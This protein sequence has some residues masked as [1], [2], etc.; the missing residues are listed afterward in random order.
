LNKKK[1]KK[2]TKKK[3]RKKNEK[4]QL[5]KDRQKLKKLCSSI[6]K[7]LAAQDIDLLCGNLETAHLRSLVEMV[8]PLGENQEGNQGLKETA[9]QA[10]QLQLKRLYD[11]QL[12][13]KEKMAEKVALDKMME[14]KEVEERKSNKQDWT[15]DELSM[16]AK[17]IAKFPG[18]ATKRWEHITA[19]VN[20]VGKRNVKEVIQ[21]SKE[22]LAHKSIQATDAYATYLAKM[23]QKKATTELQ[24]K[25]TC[26]PLATTAEST[27][28]KLLQSVITSTATPSNVS[29]EKV[30][31]TAQDQ[32]LFEQ[33]LRTVPKDD[34]DRWQ[35]IAVIVQNKTKK[36]CMDRFKEIRQQILKRNQPTVNIQQST[37]NPK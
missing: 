35:K 36:Q 30:D 34:P 17:A 23:G 1:E 25:N 37:S 7:N 18:G 16:L 27:T 8:S 32:F 14:R 24:P 19:M 6:F 5:K 20:T 29:P 2:M 13:E 33:A 15:M 28:A 21:K 10:I 22:D 11:Q 12:A 31:W 3:K 26:V 4:N 9:S